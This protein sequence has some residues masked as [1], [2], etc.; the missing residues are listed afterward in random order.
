MSSAFLNSSVAAPVK[1]AS[2]VSG[3]AAAAPASSSTAMEM[4]R[5]VPDGAQSAM[6]S[7]ALA[8]VS[9]GPLVDSPLQPIPQAGAP[10]VHVHLS[11][12]VYQNHAAS[13][14]H[15]ESTVALLAEVREQLREMRT[16]FAAE[17]S[18]LPK[19]LPA[20][21][22][23]KRVRIADEEAAKPVAKKPKTDK[24]NE[25]KS[26]AATKPKNAMEVDDDDD[27]VHSV[28]YDSD[29][30]AAKPKPKKELSPEQKAR[31]AARK[32]ER[33]AEKAAAAEKE[34]RATEK[35]EARKETYH[36]G[37]DMSEFE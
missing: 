33:T 8:P 5:T 35:A 10:Q 27:Q 15:A 12:L 17:I 23:D 4:M 32:K 19:K 31:A 25:V 6:Q 24:P 28:G 20:A 1:S 36:D 22:G 16:F 29:A 14:P 7:P 3:F 9:C 34:R 37:D 30:A 2:S 11:G 21:V 18:K 26:K 13:P